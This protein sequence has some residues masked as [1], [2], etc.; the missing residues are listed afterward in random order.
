MRRQGRQHGLVRTYRILPPPLNTRPVNSLTSPQP[1]ELL[2]TLPSK[3]NKAHRKVWPGQV[4]WVRSNDI[5]SSSYKLLTWRVKTEP[6]LNLPSFLDPNHCE[7]DVE[8]E[9]GV[10][11]VKTESNGDKSEKEDGGGS[12]SY[13][14]SMSF[15]DVGMMMMEHVLDDNEEEEEEEEDGWCLV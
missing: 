4:H 7:D 13:D 14:E 8:Q 15:Y 1:S 3:P 12:H 9:A 6:V 5:A 10:E 11:K 2:T